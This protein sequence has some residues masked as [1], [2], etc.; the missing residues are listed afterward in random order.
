MSIS[1][2]Q[3]C[4]VINNTNNNRER[5]IEEENNSHLSVAVASSEAEISDMISPSI[6]SASFTE[7]DELIKAVYEE[8]IHN[9]TGTEEEGG[10]IPNQVE[11][12]EFYNRL[13]VYKPN[14]YK[15]P[16]SAIGKQYTLMLAE[17][18]NGVK[19]GMFF[20]SFK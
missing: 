10:G 14:R 7:A 17:L 16:N 19:Y 2:S 5:A 20:L 9:N 11:W 1:E 12:K 6:N 4:I 18:L 8:Y 15:I 3:H 13:V